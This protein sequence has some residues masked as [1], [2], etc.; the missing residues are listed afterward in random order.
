MAPK[1]ILDK[2]FSSRSRAKLLS[3]LLRDPEQE[4]YMR[5]LSRETKQAIGSVQREL[6]NLEEMNLVVSRR[7]ANVR[8]FRA[9]RHHYLYE[10][11]KSIVSKTSGAKGRAV[12]PGELAAERENRWGSI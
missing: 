8:F 1:T 12:D 5:Q 2:L 3:V 11:L 4:Y 9:N 10:D 6:E 7:Q